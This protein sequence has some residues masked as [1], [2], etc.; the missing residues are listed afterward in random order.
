L[1][2]CH[3]HNQPDDAVSVVLGLVPLTLL[4][5]NSGSMKRGEAVMCCVNF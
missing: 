2:Q 3:L 1:V 4:S 5:K